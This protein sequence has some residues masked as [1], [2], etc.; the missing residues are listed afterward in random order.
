MMLQGKLS[1]VSTAEASDADGPA[2][3]MA[4]STLKG[5]GWDVTCVDWHPQKGMLASGS[6][7]NNIILWDAKAGRAITKLH[8][9][10]NMV[11]Q[12]RCVH[13]TP[14][15]LRWPGGARARSVCVRVRACLCARERMR[16]IVFDCVY[17]RAHTR[18]LPPPLYAVS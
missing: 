13:H 7:D 11:T 1:Y 17:A 14:R 16:A 5:H 12:C 3:A 8:A 15:L 10:K 4:E 18:A 6:K 9:H 2:E